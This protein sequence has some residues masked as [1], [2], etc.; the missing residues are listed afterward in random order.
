MV[1][2]AAHLLLTKLAMKRSH[3]R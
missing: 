1:T 3:Y 2:C